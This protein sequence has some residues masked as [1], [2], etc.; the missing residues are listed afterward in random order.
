MR[1]PI[2]G[3]GINDAD[4]MVHNKLGVKY[5]PCP[6]YTTWKSMIERSYSKRFQEIR[7]TYIGCSVT[8]EWLIFSNF[9]VW[10]KTQD[11]QGRQLDKDI[12][13]LG[14]KEYSPDTCIFV[15]G[16]INNLLTDSAAARG[17][18]PLGVH[19]D[20]CS[21]MY[22]SMCH[23]G[24][25]QEYL[26]KFITVDEAEYTYCIFKLDLIKKAA[27]EEEAVN[28]SKLQQALLRHANLFESRANKIKLQ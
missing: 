17:D 13:V 11:W 20:K 12:L 6:Y 19:L 24:G 16:A 15:S 8:K 23:A 21:G 28:N 1:K 22:V 14:N 26:G 2:H 9:R 10:M 7:P 25:S 27:Q 18:L 5:V 4:Y 3:V